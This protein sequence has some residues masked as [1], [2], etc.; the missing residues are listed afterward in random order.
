[1]PV[2]SQ[3]NSNTATNAA[4]HRDGTTHVLFEP[5]DFIARLA[6]LSDLQRSFPRGRES[7]RGGVDRLRI[8]ASRYPE[9]QLRGPAW[10]VIGHR[11]SLMS[12]A[13]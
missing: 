8:S 10:S 7:S 4:P 11:G 6:G 5:L 1:M 3:G 12:S 13:L 2:W 9:L